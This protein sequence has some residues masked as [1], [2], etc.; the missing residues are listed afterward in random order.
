MDPEQ[1]HRRLVDL[2]VQ[3]INPMPPSPAIKPHVAE[4]IRAEAVEKVEKIIALVRRW[5]RGERV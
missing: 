4:M 1:A 5:D 3:Q 2:C